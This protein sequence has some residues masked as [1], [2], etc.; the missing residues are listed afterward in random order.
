MCHIMEA[1]SYTEQSEYNAAESIWPAHRTVEA[2]E[3]EN[4]DSLRDY[5]WICQPSPISQQNG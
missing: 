1:I 4:G 3:G 5:L 2:G